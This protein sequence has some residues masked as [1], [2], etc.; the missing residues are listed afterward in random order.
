MASQR[1]VPPECDLRDMLRQHLV[2]R[3]LACMAR[4]AALRTTAI[5]TG[6]T[7]AYCRRIRRAV[8]GF[9]GPLPVGEKGRPVDAVPVSTFEKSGYRI[10][11]VL[12]ESFPGWQ[13]NATVYVPLDHDP[14]FP[15]VVVPVGHSGKQFADYQL[16]CQYFARSGYLTVIFDPP[17]Q[18]SE[19]QPGN[20]HFTDGVRCYCVG[21]TSSKY[22]VGDALRCIDYLETRADADLTRG[23]AM[24][25]VSG[26]GTTTTFAALVD[27]RVS[28][29]GPS[30]CVSPLADLDITQCYAGCPE[31]HMWRRY[32]EGVDEI[33][34]VCAAA[35]RP[36]LLMA[37]EHDEVFR[38]ED[39]RELAEEA[40][41]FYG[42]AGAEDRFEFFVDGRGHCYSLDQA[43]RFARFMNRWLLGDEGRVVCELPDDAFVLDPY[44]EVRC[45]PRTDVNMRTLAVV[46]ADELAVRR[47]AG[48]EAVRRGAA[49]VAGLAP[50]ERGCGRN[51]GVRAGKPFRIWTHMWQ[52]LMIEPEEG[53][54]LPATFLYHASGSAAPSLL[55]FDDRGRH[56]LLLRHGLLGHAVRFLDRERTGFNLLTVDLR[57]WGDTAMAAYP[58]E[59]AGWGGQDRFAA[60]MS[61]A[62]GDHVMAMR[63][64]DGLS[65]LA[66]LR[67]REETA[68]RKIVVS[69][70]GLGGVVALHVAAV[71]GGVDGVVTM[72]SLA[73]FRML[74]AEE[75]VAWPAD[76]FLP[77]ALMHYDLPELAAALP[78]PVRVFDPL[79]GAGS[80][81]S[82][83]ACEELRRACGPRARVLHA[84]Q[85]ALIEELHALLEA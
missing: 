14:P 74:V 68:G 48:A 25:G 32:A 8:R 44:D 54:E 9:Y 82:D 21:E 46:S 81:L 76:A 39:T 70:S 84:Q 73:S 40:R 61:A 13:V 31:T 29:T 7:D 57:G 15:A 63:V 4:A 69:G 18:A 42:A 47:D 72:D 45:R 49:N 71:D 85:A 41:V 78:C 55:H 26:G 11:N 37:G 64:R 65:A 83:G 12:F 1:P 79:D 17:G 52:Q 35:P 62:L 80:Q 3:S 75:T 20:D 5:D 34:L 23:V 2:C 16:P 67:T 22:F 50:G 24:T 27:D 53:I 51:P 56:R 77:N 66:H 59:A 36:V 6:D 19:K 38:I 10:E 30:C 43:R 28:V 60:Y 33:D 58:Y